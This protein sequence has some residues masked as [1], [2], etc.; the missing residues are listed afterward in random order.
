MRD[1]ATSP[2]ATTPHETHAYDLAEIQQMLAVMPEPAATILPL[3]HS[4]DYG[5]ASCRACA[6]RI[7][8]RGRFAFPALFGR[9]M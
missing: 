6:G 5:E 4:P 9:G 3:L 8:A 2:K 1:T 7:T